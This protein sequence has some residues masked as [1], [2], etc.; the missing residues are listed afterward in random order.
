METKTLL[1]PP[2]FGITSSSN[3]NGLTY[4]WDHT[5][6]SDTVV[7]ADHTLVVRVLPSP[8]VVL[9]AHIVGPLV[10]HKATALHLDGVASVEVAV[11]VGTVA[12]ALMRAPLEVSVFV[13][14]NLQQQPDKP[15]KFTQHK[16]KRAGDT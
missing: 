6:R 11:K 7:D 13:E 3:G 10:N 8:Q 4:L 1:L 14:Y 16:Q 2:H 5:T 9:V 15:L 12:A